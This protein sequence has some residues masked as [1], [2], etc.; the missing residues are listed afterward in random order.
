MGKQYAQLT[1]EGR[2]DIYRLHADGKSRRQI[3]ALLSRSPATVSRE[4]R[5]N[6]LRTKAWAGGYAP[7]RA[8]AL[9]ERAANPSSATSR[10]TGLSTTALPK[11]ITGTACCRAAS[12]AGAAGVPAGE[13]LCCTCNTVSPFTIVLLR[14]TTAPCLDTGKPI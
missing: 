9:A 3:A 7:V 6:S 1:V 12:G 10:S 4:L 13:V 14:L 5:R 8:Q 2:I 11:R